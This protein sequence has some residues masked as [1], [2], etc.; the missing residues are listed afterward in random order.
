M[1]VDRKKENCCYR[2]MLTT[3]GFIE[4]LLILERDTDI[5]FVALCAPHVPSGCVKFRRRQTLLWLISSNSYATHIKTLKVD[6]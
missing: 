1:G 4:S 3:T 6:G 2:K 5:S